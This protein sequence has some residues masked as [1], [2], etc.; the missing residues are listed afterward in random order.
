MGLSKWAPGVSVMKGALQN[1]T[2]WMQAKF[3][4]R[5]C[6]C[7]TKVHWLANWDATHVACL[8]T[9]SSAASSCQT[10]SSRCVACSRRNVCK[11]MPRKCRCMQYHLHRTC[12]CSQSLCF[13]VTM[14]QFSMPSVL[15]RKQAEKTISSMFGLASPLNSM[16]SLL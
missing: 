9:G 16:S 5:A 12:A 2:P 14:T 3:G 4:Y 13:D 8:T 7:A 10:C 1:D 11:A 6:I 15:K